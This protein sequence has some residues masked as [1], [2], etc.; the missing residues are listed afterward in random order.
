[1]GGS[2]AASWHKALAR[3]L[4]TVACRPSGAV[5]GHRPSRQA[6]QPSPQPCT[7][8]HVGLAPADPRPQSE[9]GLLALNSP[10]AA[11]VLLNGCFALCCAPPS[12]TDPGPQGEAGG[13][14]GRREDQVHPEEDQVPHPGGA[15]FNSSYVSR[16]CKAGTTT[17]LSS[18][19]KLLAGWLAGWLWGVCSPLG[20]AILPCLPAP[21]EHRSK[22][23]RRSWRW[24][25]ARAPSSTCPS[26]ARSWWRARMERRR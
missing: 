11:L 2:C 9:G 8:W 16:C 20:D 24:A 26:A 18:C 13:G 15:P 12:P 3:V 21:L 23:M 17:P 25:G 6:G 10:H 7:S 4:F 22:R 1:M 5:R 14:C 19:F